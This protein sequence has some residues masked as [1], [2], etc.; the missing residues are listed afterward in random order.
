[1]S[2]RHLVPIAE[3]DARTQVALLDLNNRHA[4]ETSYLTED[5]WRRMIGEAFAATCF[6][7]AGALLIAFDENAV[8]DSPNF[9]WMRANRDR[10]VYVDRIIVSADHRGGGRARIL[11]EDLFGLAR[12][13]G[14]DRIVCEVNRV[15]PNPG[16]DAFHERLGFREIGRAERD[17]GRKTVRYLERLLGDGSD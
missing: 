9:L 1:M 3:A 14:H 17:A 11:Y 15:P 6:A 12:A 16:S 2:D 7:D 5:A 10:F 8:Y 13:A 4:R